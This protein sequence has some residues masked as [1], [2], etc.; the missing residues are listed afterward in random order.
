MLN[1]KW[2]FRRLYNG[3]NKHVARRIMPLVLHPQSHGL[4]FET[5]GTGDG[6][7]TIP[8]SIIGP[9]SICYCVGVGVNATFD[10]ELARRGSR[11][12][13]FDPT[14][15]AIQYMQSVQYDPQQL[16][17]APLGVW[18]QDTDLQFFAPFDSRHVNH[19]VVDL[20]GTGSFFTAHCKRLS[21]I[22]R[23]NGHPR[24]DLLKMDIEGAWAPVVENIVDEKIDIAVLAVELDSPTS[25]SRISRI[26]RKLK[27]VDLDLVYFERENYLFVKRDRLTGAS[28]KT[29]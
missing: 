16:T 19:S 18:K 5:L 9:G 28:G 24:I 21:T 3:V 1:G 8:T 17:F 13:S 11:V 10:M 22:M 14:P 29:A 25:M 12:Y 15:R 2:K 4:K 7:W 20:H 6:G 27:S 23:E 26:I